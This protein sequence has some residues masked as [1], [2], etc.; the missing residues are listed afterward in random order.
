MFQ[1]TNFPQNKGLDKFHKVTYICIVLEELCISVAGICC[2]SCLGFR[3]LSPVLHKF[4]L[5][6]FLLL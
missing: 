5:L 3:V 4:G 2:V 1:A 6:L